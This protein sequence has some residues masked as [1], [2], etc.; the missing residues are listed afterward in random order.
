M[1][2]K[3]DSSKLGAVIVGTGFG[4]LTHLRAMRLADIEVHALV[5]RDPKKTADRAKRSDVPLGLTSLADALALPGVDH[6]SVA[7]PP[8]THADIVLEAI[9]AG[10]HVLCEKPFARDLKEA[11]LMQAAAEKAGVV[12]AVGME[13]RFDTGQALV[14]RAIHEGVIGDPRMATFLMHVPVL[15]D[16]KSE[17]PAWW[18]SKSDGGGWLGAYASHIIDQVRFTIGEITGLSASLSLIAD[19]DWSADDSYTVHFRT[20]NGCDGILQ[21]TAGAWGP[22]LMGTRIAGSRGTIWIDGDWIEGIKVKVADSSGT[23]TLEVPEDLKTLPPSPPPQ[24]LMKTAYDFL[25]AAGFDIG[26]C[27]K[28]YETM[29]D[30]ILGRKLPSNPVHATF[31]DG[32]RC[33]A[34][35]DAIR[36]SSEERCWVELSY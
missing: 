7:T 28:V 1:N 32:T 33:Q 12:N 25:H 11:K 29:R 35:L 15:A 8:H 6:V 9:A 22:I 27:T 3:T 26:P 20:A 18:S 19:H 4:V 5:G 30:K 14:A 23:R 24:E 10:K 34:I 13:F 16:P 21:S 36:K 2:T 31:D 17:V